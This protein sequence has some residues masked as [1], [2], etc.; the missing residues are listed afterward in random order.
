MAA[1][2][3]NNLRIQLPRIEE[4]DV[5][6]EELDDH[7]TV[8]TVEKTDRFTVAKNAKIYD[9]I[10]DLANA[11][12]T[13]KKEKKRSPHITIVTPRGIDQFSIYAGGSDRMTVTEGLRHKIMRIMNHQ[14]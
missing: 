6:E 14:V 8:V 13:Q 9:V 11:G 2:A 5:E 10:K 3:R 4:T 12:C 1:I 7:T